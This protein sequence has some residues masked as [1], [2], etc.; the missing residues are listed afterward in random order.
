MFS[1]VEYLQEQM[2]PTL[3]DMPHQPVANF[4][5]HIDVGVAK[6]STPQKALMNALETKIEGGGDSCTSDDYKLAMER[7]D[8]GG[9]PIEMGKM[10]QFSLDGFV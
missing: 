3:S 7:N 5:D 9:T 6:F 1:F 4:G 8:N 10:S 2:F